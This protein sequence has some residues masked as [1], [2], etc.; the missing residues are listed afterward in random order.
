MKS[1]SKKLV[2]I[3]SGFWVDC[4]S[5]KFDWIVEN[6][7]FF[8]QSD[9]EIEE[10]NPKSYQDFVLT[11]L[12]YILHFMTVRAR[13][14]VQ[15]KLLESPTRAGSAKLFSGIFDDETNGSPSKPNLISNK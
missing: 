4:D 11:I 5:I 7:F 12:R 6:L 9:F 1:H 3:V 10:L 8:A 14:L 2:W 15:E 13:I